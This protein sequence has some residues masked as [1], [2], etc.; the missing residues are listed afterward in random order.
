MHINCATQL[1]DLYDIDMESIGLTV[2]VSIY[3]R[4]KR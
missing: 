4:Y 2:T 1:Q 3:N